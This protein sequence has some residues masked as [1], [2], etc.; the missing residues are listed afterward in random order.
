MAVDKRRKTPLWDLHRQLGAKLIDFGGWDLPVA[1]PA[2][3]IREHTAVRQ[4]VG[5]FDVSHMG[6]AY[7]RGGAAREVVS[8]LTTNT[9]ESAPVGK[10]VY[11]L[12]CRPSGG[13]VDDC[14][15]YRRSDDEFYAIIN[16]AN[17]TKDVEWF[18]EHAQTRCD[19]IDV[20]DDT[21]LIAV[22]GP[23]AATTIDALSN[24]S[25]AKMPRFT[26]CDAV[27]AGVAC[28]VARTGYTGEDGFE[29]ACAADAAPKL[30][31]ALYEVAT[32]LGGL[33][34]GLGARDTLRLE[35]RLPLYGQDLDEDHTPLEA[36]L[37][38]AVK[39]E[40]AEFLGRAALAAQK[41]AGLRRHLI[42]FTI[43]ES[44]RAIAR[45]GYRV[46]LG[47]TEIG[48]VT[49]GGPGITVGGAIGL[50]YVDSAASAAGTRLTV[51]CRGKRVPATVVSGKFY[52]RAK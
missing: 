22:Q 4:A 5:L 46:Q 51:D 38:W 24:G 20:S 14:I 32:P 52:P 29:L 19:V 21:A 36:G 16:A 15:F 23:K 27:V 13:I 10:A 18:R 47:D 1:Y 35:A 11:T 37:G 41:A 43:D 40:K 17:R 2:G 3:T 34:I 44:A 9:C 42:G 8:R 25:L 49:S 12:L 7:L 48:V 26:C 33:P 6:E 30:W 28:M 50:A 39:F 45:H 31:T